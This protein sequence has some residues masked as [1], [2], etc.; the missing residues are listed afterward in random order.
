MNKKFCITDFGAKAD[1]TLQT[2]KI[3]SAIDACFLAGGG[4]VIIPSGTFL[5][6]SIRLRSNVTLYLKSGATLKGS[7]NPE[8]YFGYLNDA[9]EPLSESEITNAG[10]CGLWNIWGETAYDSSDARYNFKRIAG[11]RWN[12]AVIRAINA[13]NIAIIGEENSFIDGDNCYDAIGEEDYRGPHAITFFNV[14]NI[15]LVGYSVQHSANW[16]HNLLFCENITVKNIK[17]FA[18]HDGF[19]A[20]VCE[21]ITIKDSEFYTGDD[22]IA[23]FGNVNVRVSNCILNSACS[24]FRFGGTNVFVTDCKIFAPAKYAF[25][26]SLKKEEKEQGIIATP[27]R[28][29]AN[30]LSAFTY[31]A[32]YSLPIEFEPGNIVIKNC[33]IDGADKLLHYNFSGNE[34]WQRYRPLKNINFEDLTVT[35]LKAPSVAYGTNDEPIE[36]SLKNIDATFVDGSKTKE[37]LVVNNCKKLNVENVELKNFTGNCFVLINGKIKSDIDG[38]NCEIDKKNFIKRTKKDF[39]IRRI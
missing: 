17:V 30:M 18:G 19:D 5:I 25:R 14:K 11:S 8:D 29:R 2:D 37:F 10:Y 22:C 34:F 26:G 28:A 3:Q 27:D 12:N 33:T 21:N 7:R 4:E 1:G 35:G 20:S 31:Y 16:A 36:L 9:V 24:A 38:L 23:G 13:E 32:D 39:N 6:G 15:N